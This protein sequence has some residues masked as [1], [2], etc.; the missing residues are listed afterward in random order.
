M[1]Y[2]EIFLLF[3]VVHSFSQ[4]S[5]GENVDYSGCNKLFEKW[6]G[7]D[8]GLLFPE[9]KIEKNGRVTASPGGYR[10]FSNDYYDGG[11]KVGSPSTRITHR[12][13]SASKK[14]FVTI[15]RR[16]DS[17]HVKSVEGILEKDGQGW[18]NSMFESE[19]GR[20]NSE[21]K[22]LGHNF[23]KKRFIYRF[24]VKGGKCVPID[25]VEEFSGK[26]KKRVLESKKMTLYNMA[27]CKQLY[28]FFEESP[29]TKACFDSNLSVKAESILLG[30]KIGTS[31]GHKIG[32]SSMPTEVLSRGKGSDY[33]GSLEGKIHALMMKK[34]RGSGHLSPEN[35]KFG[36][37]GDSLLTAHNILQ[38]CHLMGLSPF[39]KDP[40]IWEEK[41]HVQESKSSG[42]TKS[43]Q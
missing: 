5:F 39:L 24:E 30:H 34:S 11:K 15:V 12:I 16:D 17:G 8:K 20:Y 29:Q 31:H 13:S 23:N 1:K 7:Y 35:K 9:F 22:D 18:V 37:L 21:F 2:V 36:K 38:D 28:D 27:L 10:T 3:F 33:Y 25:S 6:R 19:S 14:S 43:T 42:S 41:G 40:K 26:N 32:T 4:R